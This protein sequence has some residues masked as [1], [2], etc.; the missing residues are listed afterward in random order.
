MVA[1]PREQFCE[2]CGSRIKT[3]GSGEVGC[4]ACLLGAGLDPLAAAAGDSQPEAPDSLGNYRIC[5]DANGSAQVLGRGTMGVTYCAEDISLQRKVALKIINAD[6]SRHNSAARERFIREARAAASLRHPHIATVYQFGIDETT[7]Q[8]F[9]AMEYIEGETL[10]ERIRRS[11]PL[12]VA[13]VLEIARQIASA[14]VAAEKQKVVHRDLKPGNVMIAPN[15]ETDSVTVKIIDF[16]LA[17][18]LGETADPRLLTQDGF[19]GTPAFA[20]P[21]QLQRAPVDLRSDVYSLGALLWYLLT[22][23]LPFGDRAPAKAPLEQLHGAHVPARFAQLLCAMLEKEPSARPGARELFAKLQ[24][25]P[26]QSASRGNRLLLASCGALLIIVAGLAF[27]FSRS[28]PPP[29]KLA[30]FPEQVSIPEKSIAVLPFENLGDEKGS[31]SFALGVQDELLSNLAHI[32]ALKVVS[33][34]SVLQYKAGTPRNLPEIARQ[35][36]VAFVVEGTVRTIGDRVRVSAQL[37]DARTDLHRWAQVY[38]RSLDDVFGIQSEIAQTIAQQLDAAIDPAE[39]AAI[40][41]QPTHDLEAFTLYNQARV[42]LDTTTFNSR[43][44]ANLLE[45]AQLLGEAVARDP[46]FL[47]AWCE[48]ARA[49]D[50]LYF[51]GLDHLPTRVSLGE[52]AVNTALKLQPDS[53]EAHLARA[54][55]LYQC[56]LAYAPAMAELEIARRTLPNNAAV[57]TLAGYIN[58]RQGKMD[59]SVRNFE[60]ALALDPRNLFI[61][62]Q[63][64]VSYSSLRRYADAAAELDRALLIAP[65]S[66]ELR[67]AR[68]EVDLNWHAD[69]RPLHAVIATILARNPAAAADIAG[70]SLFVAFCERDTAAIDRAVAALGDGSFGPNAMQFRQIFWKGLAARVRGDNAAAMAAFQAARD[71]Q[72]R[73]VLAEPDYAPALCLLAVIDAALGKKEEAIREGR[74]AV[75]LLPFARDSVNGA[76]MIEFLAV[77]Y[78]W[79]GEPALACEEL[80]A[81]LKVPGSLSYGQLKLSPMWDNLRGNARFE[82]ILASLAPGKL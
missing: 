12:D 44:K 40:E 39:K 71:E 61:F 53:G 2:V 49:H 3:T 8:C 23:H 30:Q 64:S 19:V 82:K 26:R 6:F 36:R 68:A 16:G 13:T 15:D 72:N 41:T 75:E 22:G 67:L 38:D 27:H 74:R 32:A 78:A 7:G 54:L 48:L 10:E 45:A 47:L 11:G 28:P 69:T 56:Y 57:F 17:K 24:T 51:L 55:H 65:N 62:Q 37:I 4:L 31:A 73:K 29:A 52:S 5:C 25:F 43:G 80:T 33:R 66:I 34:T 76:H 79:C 9:C 70:G 14:L 42:L 81:A 60:D 18:A 77:T 20:S 59:E 1:P 35:L 63:T 50:S 58:R 21:E 46:N